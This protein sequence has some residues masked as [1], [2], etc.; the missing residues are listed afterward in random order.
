MSGG[1]FRGCA[2]LRGSAVRRL[3][4]F[5]RQSREMLRSWDIRCCFFLPAVVAAPA[6]MSCD[7]PV[8]TFFLHDRSIVLVASGRTVHRVDHFLTRS[9]AGEAWDSPKRAALGRGEATLTCVFRLV[10]VTLRQ[11]RLLTMFETEQFARAD[12]LTVCRTPRGTVLATKHV[13]CHASAYKRARG[14]QDTMLQ[15]HVSRE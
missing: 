4:F 3:P 11:A 2:D 7:V 14:L 13:A 10:L 1:D 5:A 12:S 9:A 15:M 8:F 6:W